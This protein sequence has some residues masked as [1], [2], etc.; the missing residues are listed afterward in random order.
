VPSLAY[1]PDTGYPA[2]VESTLEVIEVGGD[3]SRR[4]IRQF[5]RQDRGA[6]LDARRQGAGL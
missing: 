3:Q 5:R 1:V 6:E 2:K 4:V